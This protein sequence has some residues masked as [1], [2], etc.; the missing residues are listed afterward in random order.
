VNGAAAAAIARVKEKE[1]HLMRRTIEEHQK[2][3]ADAMAHI[4]DRRRAP[5]DEGVTP[6][7]AQ[8][9][10]PYPVDEKTAEES[11]MYPTSDTG[12]AP[13]TYPPPRGTTLSAEEMGEQQFHRGVLGPQTDFP[14]A[15]LG[16]ATRHSPPRANVSNPLDN[17]PETVSQSESAKAGQR[18]GNDRW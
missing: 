12:T 8:E 5:R 13:G 2:A 11:N 16:G 15:G 7:K 3:V 6:E 9:S 1:R 17:A 18:Y 10:A 14:Y 4:P